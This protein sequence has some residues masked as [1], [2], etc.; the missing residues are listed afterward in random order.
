MT[1]T[2]IEQT[3]ERLVDGATVERVVSALA[4]VCREK[5]EHI[6]TIWQDRATALPFDRELLQ[7]PRRH[8]TR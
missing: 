6:R 3:L 4:Q 7:M 5:S 8:W 1:Q 2:E